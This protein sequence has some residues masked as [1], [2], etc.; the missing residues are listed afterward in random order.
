L[1]RNEIM[2]RLHAMGVPTRRGIM[3]SHLEPPYRPCAAELPN[4]EK[5]AA[6]T[7]QLPM[8]PAL[9]VTQQDRVLRALEEIA[10]EA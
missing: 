3:A 1:T 10:S 9:T 2:D 5:V 7:L 8:H 6:N 4:T